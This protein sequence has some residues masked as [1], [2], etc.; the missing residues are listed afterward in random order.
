[1]E[2]ELLT[3]LEN[4]R[5]P[6]VCSVVR[7]TRSLVFFVI[8]VDRCLSVFFICWPFMMTTVEVMTLFLP[9]YDPLVV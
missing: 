1:M 3:L 7:V 8:L 6:P 5:S 2:Q 9:L 4:G